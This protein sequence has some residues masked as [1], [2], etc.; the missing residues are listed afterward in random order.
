MKLNL[1]IIILTYLQ[2]IPPIQESIAK[3]KDRVPRYKEKV[4]RAKVGVCV[5]G[6]GGDSPYLSSWSQRWTRG[7]DVCIGTLRL[8]LASTHL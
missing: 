6:E 2:G 1:Y 5:Y 3:D 7:G 4:K 8:P